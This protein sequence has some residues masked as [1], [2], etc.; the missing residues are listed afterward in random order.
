MLHSVM[1]PAAAHS[2]GQAGACMCGGA[3]MSAFWS[4]LLGQAK[5]TRVSATQMTSVPGGVL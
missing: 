2:R 5:Q 1:G 4:G 3:E